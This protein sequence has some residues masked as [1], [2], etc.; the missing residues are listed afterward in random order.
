MIEAVKKRVPPRI[1]IAL[2]LEVQ[3]E[4]DTEDSLK[5]QNNREGSANQAHD[6]AQPRLVHIRHDQLPLL[7]G[8]SPSRD[9]EKK[10]VETIIT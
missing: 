4:E 1:V 6:P 3:G 9:D 7:Q 10:V 8:D 2:E 5:G